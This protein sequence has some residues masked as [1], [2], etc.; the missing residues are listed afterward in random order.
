MNLSVFTPSCLETGVFK[1]HFHITIFILL[2]FPYSTS[3]FIANLPLQYPNTY[4]LMNTKSIGKMLTFY[5]IKDS[6]L[7][8]QRFLVRLEQI[9]KK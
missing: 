3:T 6:L 2:N 7:C 5:D 1:Y 9:K 4:R 8:P